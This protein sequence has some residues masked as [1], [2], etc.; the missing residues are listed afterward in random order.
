MKAFETYKAEVENQLDRKIKVV[1]SDRGGEYYGRYDK[2]GQ[3]P[4][5][6][7]KFLESHGIRTEYTL[8]GSPH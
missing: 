8:P 5:P 4:D 1:E 2:S 3:N 7:A 6:F